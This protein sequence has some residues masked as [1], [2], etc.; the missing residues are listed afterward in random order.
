MFFIPCDSWK[1]LFLT[2][3]CRYFEIL[4]TTILLLSLKRV[5][6]KKSVFYVFLWLQCNF[7]SI[8]VI[9][10]TCFDECF[11]FHVIAGSHYFWQMFVVTLRFFQPPFCSFLW[12]TY[13]ERS[14]YFTYF[15]AAVQFLQCVCYRCN[16]LRWMF[17]IPCDSWKP[18][19]LT[20]VCRYFEILSTTI[21]FLS[22]KHV[23]WKKSVFYVFYGRS[24]VLITVKC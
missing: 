11:L 22:L 10:A 21:L 16:L 15:M 9:D 20:N 4:S 1:P 6:W 18:L 14:P 12:N 19:F 5:F 13:F 17:F 23:F 7:S 8:Y 2:K 24:A 3:V